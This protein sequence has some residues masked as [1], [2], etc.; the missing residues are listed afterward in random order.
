MP[1]LTEGRL[2]FEFPDGWN[3]T[4]LDNWSFYRKQ[5]QKLGN[6]IRLTCG[7]CDAEL[8]CKQCDS[9]KTVGIKCV[10]FLALDAQQ[11]CW[12][13]EVKDYTENRRTKTIDLAD[14]TALKVRDSLSLLAVASRNANDLD[15]KSLA[16]RAIDSPRIRVVLHLEQPTKS[17]R[18][19]PHAIDP[20]HVRQRLKQLIKSVD[21]HPQVSGR[22]RMGV[23]AEWTAKPVRLDR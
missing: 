17:S 19:F 23:A 11:I 6:G 2:M 5:F 1:T 20:A 13:I 15:E 16:R 10:D 4:Q 14:E 21:P 9:A 3:V 8:R 18:L 22:A 7:H 12:L